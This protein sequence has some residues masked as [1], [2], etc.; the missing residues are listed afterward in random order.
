MAQVIDNTRQFPA[1]WEKMGKNGAGA[2]ILAL[3][4][5]VIG[6]FLLHL[7]GG[8]EMLFYQAWMYGWIFWMSVTLGCFIFMLLT[9]ITRA[10]WGFPILRLLEA[11]AKMFPWMFVMFLPIIANVWMG[12]HSIYPWADYATAHADEKMA[13]RYGFMNPTVW[14]LGTI[15]YFGIWTLITYLLS[16]LSADQDRTRD[17]RIIQ[18][19]VD[20]SSI[21]FCVMG[22]SGTF[23]YV[24][25]VMSLDRHWYSTIY[26][27]WYLAG[28]A[29]TALS[30]MV[31][32]A[33]TLFMRRQE[34]YAT[35]V[36]LKALK[37]W[38]NLMLTL[39]MVWAYFSVSQ[40]II[41]WSGNLPE[42][43]TYYIQRNNGT[44]AYVTTFL[45]FAMFFGPFLCLISGRTKRT[46]ILL[47]SVAIWIFGVR[48]L[49]SF[50]NIVPFYQKNLYTELVSQFNFA[51]LLAVIG[52]GGLWMFGFFWYARRAPLQS[53]E[54]AADLKYLEE[55]AHA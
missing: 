13:H 44:T 18:R 16:R 11:G 20:L 38:G 7:F 47:R 49:E 37:D 9:N 40:Y 10:T 42:E 22:L 17:G 53:I 8:T 2:G 48:I 31:I 33:T 21:S 25:W 1:E 27:A 32:I 4:G 50:W 43:I 5:L 45:V 26:A 29:L 6:C 15:L 52:I 19:R 41:T 34:P 36:T 35:I 14:T 54:D 28:S 51:Y 23:A 3:A 24:H 30:F 39:S 55:A 46:P 12:T